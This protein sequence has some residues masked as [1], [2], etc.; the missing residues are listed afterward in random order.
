MAEP[1]LRTMVFSIPEGG[2]I[3]I[4]Y[5]EQMTPESIGMTEE[6]CLIWFRGLRRRAIERQRKADADA[7]YLSWVPV[8]VEGSKS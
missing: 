7:E 6:L 3:V 1:K 4:N 5:P 8:G 2:E